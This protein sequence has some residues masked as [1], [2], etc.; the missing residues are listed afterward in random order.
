M[1][2]ARAPGRLPQPSLLPH[3]HPPLPPTTSSRSRRRIYRARAITTGTSTAPSRSPAKTRWSWALNIPLAHTR[4]RGPQ[5]R[6]RQRRA[7][8]DGST[9]PTV[10]PT[11]NESANRKRWRRRL[12][13][14]RPRG[15]GVGRRCP[16]A[17]V[18]RVAAR[19]RPSCTPPVAAAAVAEA[20]T[21]P[22][23]PRM[24]PFL[25]TRADTAAA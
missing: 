15:S 21:K 3:T 12:R 13:S 24:S 16:A 2:M 11:G 7:V 19:D 5:Q 23:A 9:R 1:L 20:V 10:A 18:R 8:D 25:A 6:Q 22:A 17:R 14:L 4:S